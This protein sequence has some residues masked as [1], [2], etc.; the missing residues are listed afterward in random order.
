MIEAGLQLEMGLSNELEFLMFDKKVSEEL[1]NYCEDQANFD[2]RH[3][4]DVLEAAK[5]DHFPPQSMHL[6]PLLAGSQVT[7]DYQAKS[8]LRNALWETTEIQS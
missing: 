6:L 8:W 5:K 2:L 1:Y 4:T 3:L 7:M